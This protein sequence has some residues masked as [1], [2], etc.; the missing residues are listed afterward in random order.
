MYHLHL[1]IFIIVEQ[2][3]THLVVYLERTGSLGILLLHRVGILPFYAT[4][5]GVEVVH[6]L[7]ERLHVRV[8]L[9]TARLSYRDR[10]HLSILI[11]QAYLLVGLLRHAILVKVNQLQQSFCPVFAF[12]LRKFAQQEVE[13]GV[14]LFPLRYT[15]GQQGGDE[16]IQTHKRLHGSLD[17]CLAV[18]AVFLAYLYEAF[19]A[20]VEYRIKLCAIGTA[21]VLP[22]EVLYFFLFIDQ[23]LVADVEQVAGLVD[24]GLMAQRCLLVILLER[25][26]Y[27]FCRVHEVEHLGILLQRMHPVQA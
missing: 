9:P 12:Q 24:V 2:C 23:A 16:L 6:Y 4:E 11:L 10:L 14:F 26:L 25:L 1:G 7:V 5:E 17:L 13:E 3:I 19:S 8:G 18:F 15:F 20:S 21:P 22:V 27:V